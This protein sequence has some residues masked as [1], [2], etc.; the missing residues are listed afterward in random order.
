MEEKL[1]D[2]ENI[3]IETIYNKVHREKTSEERTEN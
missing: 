1:S 3:A 2:C